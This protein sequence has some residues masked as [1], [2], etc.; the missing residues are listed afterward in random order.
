M[1][2]LLV[3]ILPGCKKSPD[4]DGPGRLIISLTDA[5]F[6]FNMIESASVT[7]TKV[8]I[9][10]SCDCIPDTNP[11]IVLWEGSE[12][13]NLLNLRN[14]L[15]EELLN[16]EI[17]QGEYDLIRLYVEEAG[18]KVKDGD[19]YNLKIPSGKQ[20]GIKIF[21]N[22]GLEVEGGL[23]SELLL[24]FDLARSF[25]MR[26]NYNTPAGIK[27]FIFKPVIRAVNNTT[28]GRLEGMVTDTL[29]VKIKEAS[30][31]VVKDTIVASTVADTLGHY[32]IIGLPGGT[33]SVFAAKEKYDTVKVDGVKIVPGNRTILN[34]ILPGK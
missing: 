17:P 2:A 6:P 9:R 7:I 13:F 21:I 5:P 10:K 33:Y 22:P 28:A 34:F 14:G 23:S 27:G 29:K 11:F 4:S 1:A 25:V 24:D 31:W 19:D 3:L 16:I 26:G 18:L 15:K 20:T 8:E 30:V 32:A 12:I